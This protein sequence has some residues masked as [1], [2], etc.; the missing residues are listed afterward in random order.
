MGFVSCADNGQIIDLEGRIA[1][2]GSAFNNHLVIE[3]Q[4]TGKSYTIDNPQSYDLSKKQ[5]LIVKLKANIT[6][7][8]IGPGLPA[9][10]EVI[11]ISN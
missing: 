1:M 11:E 4:K 6:K 7:E 8:R 2:Q 10:I 9:H 5:N 3:D